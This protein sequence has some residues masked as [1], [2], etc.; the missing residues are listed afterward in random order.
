M[1][2][3]TVNK[4]LRR[5]D[6]RIERI[7][8]RLGFLS[9]KAYFRPLLTQVWIEITTLSF[10]DNGISPKNTKLGIELEAHRFSLEISR[11]WV[12][13]YTGFLG[14]YAVSVDGIPENKLLCELEN[15]TIPDDATKASLQLRVSQSLTI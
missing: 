6:Q 9:G 15:L 3:I 13:E 2:R 12:N 14:D 5:V 4:R 10:K 11:D 7:D 1:T 8:R